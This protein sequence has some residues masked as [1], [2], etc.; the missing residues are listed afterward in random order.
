MDSATLQNNL[1]L[2]KRLASEVTAGKKRRFMTNQISHQFTVRPRMRH[3][4]KHMVALASMSMINALRTRN[5]LKWLLWVWSGYSWQRERRLW[6]YRPTNCARCLVDG[7]IAV[8]NSWWRVE[9][10]WKYLVRAEGIELWSRFELPEPSGNAK[11]LS[12]A[13]DLISRKR[14]YL[15]SRWVVDSRGGQGSG[16]VLSQHLRWVSF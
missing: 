1:Q 16:F 4:A 14:R 2:H 5:K 7:K 10:S 11:A 6:L 9:E 8:K 3:N 13:D 12:A 15:F